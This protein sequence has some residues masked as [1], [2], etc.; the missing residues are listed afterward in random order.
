MAAHM[1]ALMQKREQMR[2][3]KQP[4]A[5]DKSEKLAPVAKSEKPISNGV[6]RTVSTPA[7]SS[8]AA[9][10]AAGGDSLWDQVRANAAESDAKKE[11]VIQASAKAASDAA[12]AVSK[13]AELVAALQKMALPQSRLANL[14]FVD[15]TQL[16]LDQPTADAFE[17][18]DR[19]ITAAG[20]WVAY[21][22]AKERI[23]V[24]SLVSPGMIRAI[25][26]LMSRWLSKQLPI[27]EVKELDL[28]TVSL[29]KHRKT[30]R[31]KVQPVD[32]PT[33]LKESD[34]AVIL[35]FIAA[36]E[37]W[38]ALAKRC[39]VLTQVDGLKDILRHSAA[40]ADPGSIFNEY[41]ELAGRMLDRVHPYMAFEDDSSASE[42]DASEELSSS[43]EET[44]QKKKRR[45]PV[46]SP[47]ASPAAPKSKRVKSTPKNSPAV[48]ASSSSAAAAASS[49][50][51]ADVNGDGVDDDVLDLR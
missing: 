26:S 28:G 43:D 48:A 33:K 35:G 39:V 20:E 37:V 14:T 41:R 3:A 46:D 4:P 25:R 5:S 51:S 30:H 45:P 7:S 11:A 38:T 23:T 42:S 2:L 31:P 27:R 29:S 32:M 13:K 19:F 36:W 10:A 40:H 17:A 18:C 22:T 15:I 21:L 44:P 6:A 34:G 9:A 24:A 47:A 49:S 8:S 12:K 16:A 50:K 1:Q